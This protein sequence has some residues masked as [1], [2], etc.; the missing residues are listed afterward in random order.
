TVPRKQYAVDEDD[1]DI[2][3]SSRNGAI[4]LT[5]GDLYGNGDSIPHKYGDAGR[6]GINKKSKSDYV[7]R[8]SIPVASPEADDEDE[9]YHTMRNYQRDQRSWEKYCQI[10]SRPTTATTP[11]RIQWEYSKGVSLYFVSE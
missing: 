11:S 9:D 1:V 3:R 2:N 7:Y 10:N 4:T 6:Y 8:K 5:S